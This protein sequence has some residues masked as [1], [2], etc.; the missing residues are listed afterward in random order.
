[1]GACIHGTSHPSVATIVWLFLWIDSASAVHCISSTWCV[2][3]QGTY[4]S[5]S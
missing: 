1:M 3:L 4:F 5:N 2:L